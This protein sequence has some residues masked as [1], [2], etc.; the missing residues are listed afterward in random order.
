MSIFV[1]QKLTRQKRRFCTSLSRSSV[2]MNVWFTASTGRFA[3]PPHFVYGYTS[4]QF[5]SI[6]ISPA[7]F[8]ESMKMEMEFGS[9]V[10]LRV[11]D[12]IWYELW[13]CQK[14]AIWLSYCGLKVVAVLR[15]HH[16]HIK[17]PQWRTSWKSQSLMH[18]WREEF[19]NCSQVLSLW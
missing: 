3:F 11:S 14:Q 6:T 16:Q 19:H 17:H 18:Y 9:Q 12:L 10:H 7:G 4:S 13:A 8:Q 1:L 15:A 5:L 2:G